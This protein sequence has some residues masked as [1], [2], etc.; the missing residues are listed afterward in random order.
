[1]CPPPPFLS[2]TAPPATQP[3]P[4]RYNTRVTTAAQSLPERPPFTPWQDFLLTLISWA[5]TIAVRLIGPTMRFSVSCEE[6]SP[7]SLQQRPF[8]YSF[9]HQCTF[10]ATYLW[11][12]LAIRVMSST[13]FDGEFTARMIRRF[14]FVPIRG[15]SSRG[16]VRGLLGLRKEIEAGYT[17]A[18]TIDGPRGPRFVTKPGPVLLARSSRV[19]MAV[20]HIAIDRAWILNTWDRLMI[21]QPFSRALM[22]VGSLIPV[23]E[24]IGSE[25]LE[26]YNALLQ[27]SLDRVKAFAEANV[28][29]VGS[30]EFPFF[31]R[32]QLS[33][34]FPVASKAS[35][36]DSQPAAR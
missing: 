22:R 29:R 19:P 7:L 33:G 2:T 10:A 13:S 23:P 28:E 11:R 18:F 14:G 17:V 15:S 5:T 34:T 32:H 20:F 4:P 3:A 8:V 30:A 21:P 25:H 1:L 27:A 9:W 31:R 35:T 24:D 36:S 26:H 6:N 16:A 12:D